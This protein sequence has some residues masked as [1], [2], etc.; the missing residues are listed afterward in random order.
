MAT[1]LAPPPKKMFRNLTRT[2]RAPGHRNPSSRACSAA[3]SAVTKRASANHAL[4]AGASWERSATI[5]LA[6]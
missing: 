4:W 6:S 5:H 2:P 1:L 3:A